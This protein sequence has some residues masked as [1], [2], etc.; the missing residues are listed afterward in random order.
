MKVKEA[1]KKIGPAPAA[2]RIQ[3]ID[4][5]RGLAVILMVIHH[6]LFDLVEFLDAPSWLFSNHVFNI[7]HYIFAGVFI[8]LSG[9][10]SRFSRSNI[11]RGIKVAVVALVITLVTWLMGME[12]LFGVLHLLAFCM[13]FY[14]LTRKFWDKI[15][16]KIAPFIYIAL[17]AASAVVLRL[18]NPITIKW[19]WPFGLYYKG[20]YSADYFPIFPWLFVFLFGS[21][22]G[23]LVKEHRLPEKVYTIDPPFFPAVGRLSLI[24]YVLHQPVLYGITMLIKVIIG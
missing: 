24:I 18:L 22:L 20:F 8:G 6:F 5:L 17:T 2:G 14:G 9:L 23:K 21:W 16:E 15:P 10:S 4:A 1:L 3:S 19:L 12:I 11:K 13:I 7:L